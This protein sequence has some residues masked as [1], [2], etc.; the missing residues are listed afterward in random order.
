VV[1][2]SNSSPIIALAEIAQLPLLAHLFES[3]LIPAAVAA[4]I[5]ASVVADGASLGVDAC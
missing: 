3:V 4:E 5:T 2:V 1:V